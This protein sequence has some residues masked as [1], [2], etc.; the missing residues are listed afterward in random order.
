MAHVKFY[1]LRRKDKE[2]SLT[3]TNL[4]I[5]AKYSYNG[6]R[7]EYYTRVRCDLIYFNRNYAALGKDPI[8]TIAPH[9]DIMNANLKSIERHILKIES[10]AI[11][12]GVPLTI[13]IFRNELNKLLRP[14]PE[15]PKITLKEYIDIYINSIPQRVNPRTGK[16]LSPA[17]SK[18]YG[19]IK[20]LFN[21]FCEHKGREY[22]FSD[23][24][25]TFYREFTEYMTTKKKYATNTIAR[26]LRFLKT[27]LND[28][29]TNNKNDNLEFRDILKG[30]EEDADAAYLNEDELLKIYQLD[31]SNNLKLD[32]VRDVFLIGC[33]TGL[34]FSDFSTLKKEDIDIK[35]KKIR[36]KTRKTGAKVVIPLHPI[37][38]S[39][40][41]KYNY[42]IPRAI[43][44]QRFNDYVKDVAKE[45]G[46][47]DS[48]TRHMTKGGEDVSE[49]MEKWKAV[50]S[51][52][53][54]RSF[55]TNAAN[56]GINILFIMAITGHATQKQ[57][58]SY[59][60]SSKD[61]KADKFREEAGW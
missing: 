5:I 23:I 31:L 18:K 27:V 37:V 8:K 47:K 9:S 4:P 38:V 21:D 45:A 49:T 46:I 54:R 43:T 48:F 44:N 13:D 25:A 50:S 11:A 33:F 1:P 7:L 51:H 15:K 57:F 35:N 30:S 24:N 59:I 16:K 56:K 10:D 12:S 40:L 32:R 34:R 28:A 52:T 36:V 26:S 39:I 2:G 29:V 60:K 53:A 55:A 41:E 58:M 19:T 17:M 20:T 6:K 42:E 3:D 22:D 61:E 14:E